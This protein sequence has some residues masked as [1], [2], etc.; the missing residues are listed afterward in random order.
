MVQRM[1]QQDPLL[2]PGCKVNLES[3]TI[4]TFLT[5][6]RAEMAEAE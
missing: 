6:A 4:L 2:H 1:R 3:D 5:F